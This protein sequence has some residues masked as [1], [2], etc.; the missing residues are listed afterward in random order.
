MKSILCAL[1]LTGCMQP[2]QEQVRPCKDVPHALIVK[3]DAVY[4]VT[5]WSMVGWG[6]SQSISCLPDSTFVERE[7][8]DAGAHDATPD[9][10]RGPGWWNADN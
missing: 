7:A 8:V 1:L 2:T 4:K 9:A 6:S 10:Q 5:C 3:H